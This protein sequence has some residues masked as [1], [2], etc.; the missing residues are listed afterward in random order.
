[1]SEHMYNGTWGR[2]W[3]F[4]EWGT[5]LGFVWCEPIAGSV[6]LGLP[7]GEQGMNPPVKETSLLA[8]SLM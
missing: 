8:C 5:H 6:L 1:M 7:N 3:G 4:A 2:G